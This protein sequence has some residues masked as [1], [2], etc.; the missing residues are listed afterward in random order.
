MGTSGMTRSTNFR[1]Q[2]GR[3]L[4]FGLSL[5]VLTIMLAAAA[6]QAQSTPFDSQYDSP[7]GPP[8][9]A[10]CG[11]DNTD[12]ESGESNSGGD[13]ET[14][15]STSGSECGEGESQQVAAQVASPQAEGPQVLPATGGLASLPFSTLA[16]VALLGI[17]IVAATGVVVVRRRR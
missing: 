11:T 3:V 14:E 1:R 2:V 5:I 10:S 6:A 9:A 4:L 12:G 7:T 15:G 13:P 17:G 8:P 16:P